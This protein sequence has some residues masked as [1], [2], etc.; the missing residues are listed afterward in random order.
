MAVV[1]P[2]GRP[3]SVRNRCLIE[4]FCGVVCVVTLPF[5]HF[6]WC[7]GFCHRTGSDLLL[8]VIKT[9]W[10]SHCTSDYDPCNDIT[11]TGKDMDASCILISIWLWSSSWVSAI[12]NYFNSKKAGKR[13]CC[14]RADIPTRLCFFFKLLNQIIYGVQL[15]FQWSSQSDVRFNLKS[16]CY[17]SGRILPGVPPSTSLAQ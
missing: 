8:F 14:R 5:G 4:L 13:K 10:I 11:K 16:I 12:I 2:T 17:D 6:C 15:N 3:K 7:R 1:T 9:N